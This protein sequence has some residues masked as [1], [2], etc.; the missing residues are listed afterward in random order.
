VET[1]TC[2]TC[3]NCG[4]EYAKVT[5]VCQDCC[6]HP[7]L[8]TKFDGV[9]VSFWTPRLEQSTLKEDENND[10]KRI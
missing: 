1:E 9:S 2:K 4:N 8:R 3:D 6:W 10:Q 5:G 7:K